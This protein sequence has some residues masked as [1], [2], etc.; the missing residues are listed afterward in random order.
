MIIY[1]MTKETNM[2]RFLT[3]PIII[4]AF[5]LTACSSTKTISDDKSKQIAINDAGVNQTDITFTVQGRNDDNYHYLFE[6]ANYT[7]EYTINIY[8]GTIEDKEILIK[9][10]SPINN[11]DKIIS[12]DQ[13]KEIGL[14]YF[15]FQESDVTNLQIELDNNDTIIYY[16]IE[17]D[18]GNHQYSIIVEAIDGTCSDA[19]TQKKD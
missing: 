15:N 4:F 5:C 8:D 18:K 1:D 6:D 11:Y 12:G 10:Q 3:I 9:K 16:H 14:N 7:Y 13:A 17:F 19:L 2:K